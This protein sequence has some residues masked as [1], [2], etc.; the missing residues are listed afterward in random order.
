MA[1]TPT[2]L[3]RLRNLPAEPAGN[4][5]RAARQLLELTQQELAEK[6]KLTQSALSDMERG[7]FGRTTI[8]TGHR[9]AEFFG[10]AIEDLFPAS[11]EVA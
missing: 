8:D 1:L 9:F 6:L 7:R 10:C 4:R 2:Q 11:Q 3:K 5:I